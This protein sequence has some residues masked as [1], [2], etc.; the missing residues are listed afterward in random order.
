MVVSTFFLLDKD[1][2][3]RFFKKNYLL[4]DV[5]SETVLEMLFPTMSNVDVD[6]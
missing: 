4:A 2:Q 5:K 3:K 6:F 1:G